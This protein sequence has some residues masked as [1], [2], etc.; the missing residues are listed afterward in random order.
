M[1]YRVDYEVSNPS[2]EA[3]YSHVLVE[4]SSIPE[5][6]I[7]LNEYLKKTY[8][9]SFRANDHGKEI[10]LNSSTKIMNINLLGKAI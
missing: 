7:K 8:A 3:I 1:I 2:F 6:E 4:A 10:S 5:I 9:D